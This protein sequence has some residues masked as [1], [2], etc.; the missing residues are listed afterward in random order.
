MSAMP[1]LSCWM[2]IAAFAG[3]PILE[4][5]SSYDPPVTITPRRVIMPRTARLPVAISKASARISIEGHQAQTELTLT[6]RNAGTSNTEAELILPVPEGVIV[7]GFSY[8]NGQG[9]YAASLLPA[10][11]ARRLYDTIVARALDPALLEFAGF[12]AIRTSVFPV[13]ARSEVTLTVVYDQVVAP[14]NGRF[15]YVLPRSEALE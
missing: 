2:A 9:K 5:Q 8:G 4:A 15:D 11:E 6:V 14:E 12:D 1:S 10:H 13:P 7:K 3:T